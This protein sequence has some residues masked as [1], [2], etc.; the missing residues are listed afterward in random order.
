MQSAVRVGQTIIIIPAGGKNNN[1]NINNKEMAAKQLGEDA[2][3]FVK[4]DDYTIVSHNYPLVF[5]SNAM[6]PQGAPAPS[7]CAEGGAVKDAKSEGTQGSAMKHMMRGRWRL[8]GRGHERRKV[9][10]RGGT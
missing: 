10:D 3:Q 5:Q 4:A 1:N 7:C 2:R 8:G 6:P 9:T